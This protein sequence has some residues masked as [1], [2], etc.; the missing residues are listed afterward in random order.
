M[1]KLKIEKNINKYDISYIIL[2]IVISILLIISSKFIVDSKGTRAIIKYDGQE[3]M[4]LY[5]NENTKI[6][7]EKSKYPK[8]LGNMEIEI[9]NGKIGVIKEKSPN[10]YCSLMGFVGEGGKT[11]ICQPNKVVILIESIKNKNLD[12]DIGVF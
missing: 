2:I 3:I 8:L 9:K 6:I 7:L 10:N 1:E 12:I 11:I 4:A 5:L